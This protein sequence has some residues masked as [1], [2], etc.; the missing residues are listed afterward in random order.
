VTSP[1]SQTFVVEL[2]VWCVHRSPSWQIASVTQ[3][4]ATGAYEQMPGMPPVQ[5]SS[6]QGFESSHSPTTVQQPAMGVWVQAPLPTSQPSSV[7]LEPS[8][9]GSASES[10]Q[11]KIAT[12]LQ[13]CAV[14]WQ[15]SRVHTSPSLG[16]SESLRQQLAIDEFRQVPGEPPERSQL[17]VVQGS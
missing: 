5:V 11:S 6:V 12:E 3:Q 7:Q 17:S 15:I 9:Q 16:H 14:P 4:S 10:Q 1:A 8:G 13:V 2:Q